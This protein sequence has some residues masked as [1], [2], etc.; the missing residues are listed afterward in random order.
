MS[1]T[2]LANTVGT[3]LFEVQFYGLAITWAANS[4]QMSLYVVKILEIIFKIHW[5]TYVAC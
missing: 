5:R 2:R 1:H 3:E 4:K